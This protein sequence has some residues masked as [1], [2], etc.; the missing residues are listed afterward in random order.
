M[1]A[2]DDGVARLDR[3]LQRLDTA[4]LRIAARRSD[5]RQ[6]VDVKA[7]LDTAIVELRRLL[8]T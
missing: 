5:A 3:A 7:R 8:E 4:A 6:V 2:K 1:T